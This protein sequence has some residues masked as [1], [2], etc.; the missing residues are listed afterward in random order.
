MIVP[1]FYL[2]KKVK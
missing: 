1:L 2:E